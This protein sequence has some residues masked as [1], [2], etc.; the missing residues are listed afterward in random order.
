MVAWQE[1][2][3]LCDLCSSRCLARY[4]QTALLSTAEVHVSM[5]FL[6]GLFPM[7]YEA[8]FLSIVEPALPACCGDDGVTG[9][10]QA[11][12]CLEKVAEA[13]SFRIILSSYAL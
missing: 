8:L 4:G 3:E 1:W 6:L 10:A 13:L 9:H 5:I 7:I 2:R 12:C 11:R